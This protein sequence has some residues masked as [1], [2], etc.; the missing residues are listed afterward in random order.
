MFLM[1]DK[2]PLLEFL[3]LTNL[4]FNAESEEKVGMI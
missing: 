4:N 1:G 3:Y 2:S